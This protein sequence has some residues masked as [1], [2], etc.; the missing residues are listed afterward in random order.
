MKR[1]QRE[2]T[3]QEQAAHL[4]AQFSQGREDLQFLLSVHVPRKFSY[5]HV[6]VHLETEYTM[7]NTT[8]ALP[9]NTTPLSLMSCP[10]IVSPCHC[11]IS[12]LHVNVFVYF[13]GALLML[14]PSYL[15]ALMFIVI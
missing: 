4:L 12:M 7:F 13:Y 9:S 14:T 8:E 6:P 10:F 1:R 3:G 15:P 2:S 11:F 5:H